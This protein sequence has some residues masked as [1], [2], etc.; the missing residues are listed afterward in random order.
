MMDFSWSEEQLALR[1]SAV[2]FAQRELSHDVAERDREESFSREDWRKCAEYGIQGLAVPRKYGGSELDLLTSFL[3]MEGLGYGCRDNGLTFALNA[4]FVSVVSTLISA[5]SDAH[6]QRYLPAICAGDLIGAYAMTEPLSGSDAFNLQTTFVRTE[7]GFT[8]NGHKSLLTFGPVADFFLVFATEDPKLRHWG[9]SVFV[10]DRDTPG[11][12]PSPAISKMGLRTTP[13]SELHLSD[14]H[15]THDALLGEIGSGAAIFNEGQD[16][17]R[18]AILASQIGA[19]EFQ[20]EKTIEYAKS[21]HQSGQ[22]IGKFQSVSNRIVD[23]KMRL[24]LARLVA[25]KAVWM[26]QQGQPATMEAAIANVRMAEG[27]VRSSMDAILVHGGRGYLTE[28]EVERDLRDAVGGPVYGG[29]SDI[30][31]NIIAHQLGL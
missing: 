4:Q 2:E 22:P 18:A 11:L 6:K 8:L 5:G 23:M 31:R 14:C 30:Q 21:R 12:K 1:K 27:F 19:M 26:I 24:D 16:V 3:V 7:T 20:L 25:Y 15:V 13:M 10:I 28:T 29:T 9:I 17:E